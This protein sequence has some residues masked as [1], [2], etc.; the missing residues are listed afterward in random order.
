[1]GTSSLSGS[2]EKHTFE[3]HEFVAVTSKEV[4]TAAELAA[5][6]DEDLD[7]QEALRVR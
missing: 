5:G 6:H 7:P 3:K 2:D 1:M 4:D